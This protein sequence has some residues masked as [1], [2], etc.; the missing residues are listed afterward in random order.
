MLPC[1]KNDNEK[2]LLITESTEPRSFANKMIVRE[3]NAVNVGNNII[4]NTVPT[5]EAPIKNLYWFSTICKVF[6]G[7][8][9]S[10]KLPVKGCCIMFAILETITIMLNSEREEAINFTLAPDRRT[11]YARVSMQ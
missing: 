5:V 1:F 6:S 2:L 7:P 8:A 10:I 9:V 11:A 3:N 4:P